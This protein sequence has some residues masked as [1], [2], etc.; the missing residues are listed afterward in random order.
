MGRIYRIGIK[1][2]VHDLRKQ[3]W[4]LGEISLKM[5]IPKNTIS[6]W[7]RDIQL[8]KKQKER[9]KQKIIAS[10]AI[11][12]PLAVKVNREKIEKWKEN[13]KNKVKHFGQLPLQGPKIRKL[14]CGLLYLC[15]GAKYPSS[16]YLHFGNSDSKIIYFF[17][18]LLRKTYCIDSDKL[19]FSIGYRFDQNYEEL[20]DYWS[21]LIGIPKSK[22]LNSKPDMRTKGKPTLKEDYRGI[23]RIIYYDT[24]LQFELQ[25]IG[26]A[27]IK[28][29][30]E[31]S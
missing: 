15:E 27:I 17:I 16:K 2:K 26:E 30:A 3:G 28:N 14:I 22:C 13:I 8:T 23:C 31:G 9:I 10:G 7:V 25:A 18:N 11:G 19:R 5:K 29:G 6:G 24:S 21:N 1:M 12:R 4:S 20:K